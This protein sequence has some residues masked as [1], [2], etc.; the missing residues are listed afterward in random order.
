[1]FRLYQTIKSNFNHSHLRSNE[2]VKNFNWLLVEGRKFE[3]KFQTKFQL[4]ET[5]VLK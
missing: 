4:N 3:N 2:S 1:M 5:R